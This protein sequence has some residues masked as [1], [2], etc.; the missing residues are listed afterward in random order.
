MKS[1]QL[2]LWKEVTSYPMMAARDAPGESNDEIRVYCVE[3]I[4]FVV[5][6]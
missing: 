5:E 4:V 6:G 3:K 1:R 2:M